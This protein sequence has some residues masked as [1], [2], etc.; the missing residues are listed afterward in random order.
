MLRS[1]TTLSTIRQFSQA[2]AS[3]HLVVIGVS[4]FDSWTG[5]LDRYLTAAE[6][7]QAARWTPLAAHDA[8]LRRHTGDTPGGCLRSC[9]RAY[10]RG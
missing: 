1:E 6:I 3:T 2:G 7:G 10:K 8:W 9:R 5:C 4:V